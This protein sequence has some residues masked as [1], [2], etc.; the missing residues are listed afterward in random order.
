V[1]D[2][3]TVQDIPARAEVTPT[4]ALRHLQTAA[5]YLSVNLLPLPLVVIGFAVLLS[6]WHGVWP[7]T[8]WAGGTIAAW[9]LTIATL[10]AFL[11]RGDDV[12][13]LT[14]W[15]AAICTVLFVSTLA[16]TSVSPLFWVT[17]DR[18]NNV[19]LYVVI[20]AGLASAGAQSAPSAPVVIANLTPY[21]IVF[22]ALSLTHE[23]YPVNLG[24]A[25]LQ[26][27]YI[28]LVALYARAVWQLTHEMLVLRDEKRSLIERLQAALADA[29]R[30]RHRAEEASKAK[31]TFLANM[32]HELRTPLNAVLG[33]SEVIRD[34]VFGQGATERYANYAG[35]IYSS[36]AHLL[37]LINDILD[38]SKIEAGK[39]ELAADEFDLVGCGR[40]TL[41]FIEP[42]AERKGVR[43][44]CEAREPLCVVADEQ[45]IRQ[46]IINLLSN[47]VKFT[48]KRGTIRL[49]I[50]RAANR[51]VEITV[52]DNGVG[53]HHDDLERVMGSFA[54]GRHDIA[55]TDEQGTGLGLAIVKALAEAHGGCVKIASEVG[56]GTTVT[57]ELPAS[58][59]MQTSARAVE[60]APAA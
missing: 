4:L 57:V 9:S 17:D 11:K 41:P 33:F 24:I 31:S 52:S 46:I 13:N 36:G 5:R 38:L 1:V 44:V 2:N 28:V 54:Q 51:D 35:D 49:A 10:R 15:T 6:Q 45:A 22:L 39:R 55:T 40:A 32:S 14:R 60:Q 42:Q 59:V 21:C 56:V 18:L 16:F 29:T 43:I 58:R 3:R 7:L 12:P 19:L 37:G 27:C 20:A 8:L 30:A 48:P 23:K 26:L 53:I 50:G 25:F 34:R 47:A